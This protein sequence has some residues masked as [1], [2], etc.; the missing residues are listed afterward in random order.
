MK[1]RTRLL[2]FGAVLPVVTLLG[3]KENAPIYS[4]PIPTT[5][6]NFGAVKL[7]ITGFTP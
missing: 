3:G 5:T 7:S 2:V 4:K 1:L 6:T